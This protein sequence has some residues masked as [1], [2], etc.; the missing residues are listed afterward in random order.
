MCVCVCGGYVRDSLGS[1]GWAQLGSEL[2]PLGSKGLHP[3]R[4]RRPVEEFWGIPE[5]P[6]LVSGQGPQRFRGTL[7]GPA[8]AQ[9]GLLCG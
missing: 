6:G 5:D 3:A 4:E 8:G 2:S 1:K 9:F 7:K